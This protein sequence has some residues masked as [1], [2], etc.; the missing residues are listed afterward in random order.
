VIAYF[1]TLG[2]YRA[3]Q[4]HRDKK[5]FAFV[6]DFDVRNVFASLKRKK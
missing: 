3:L 4:T 6:L 1:I 5:F 2:I